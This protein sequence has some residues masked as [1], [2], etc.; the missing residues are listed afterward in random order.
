MLT[1]RIHRHFAGS[2]MSILSQIVATCSAEEPLVFVS[3]FAAGEKGAIQAYQLDSVKG[4]LQPIHRTEGV[5]HPFFFVISKDHKYLYSIDAKTFG[6][7]E[8]EQVA[9]YALDGRT[10]RMTL[11]NRQSTRGTACCYLEIDSTGKT[12]LVANYT[13]GNVAS[14]AVREDGSLGE[15]VSFY[16]HAGASVD[17]V[18]QKGPNAHCIVISPDNRFAFAADLG[19]DQIFGY[20]LTA[21]TA[22]LSQRTAICRGSCGS[23]AKTSHISP[24]RQV[25][26]RH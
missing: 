12:V 5:E 14:F 18:R 3:S 26:V 8:P 25:R 15:S 16:Q 19:T 4:R 22:T 20:R 9:A 17:P 10:G 23:G 2:L 7:T 6:G 1:T 11:L 21:A 24:E 13:T